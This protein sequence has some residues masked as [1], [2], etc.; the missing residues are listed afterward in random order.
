MTDNLKLDKLDPTGEDAWGN[1][2]AQF[3]NINKPE[4][5]KQSEIAATSN[6]ELASSFGAPNKER[7]KKETAKLDKLALEMRAKVNH[8]RPDAI[9][10][11]RG[12]ID[13]I[14]SDEE[15][16]W[17]GSETPSQFVD[18]AKEALGLHITDKNY[19]GTKSPAALQKDWD[20]IALKQTIKRDAGL[21]LKHFEDDRLYHYIAKA[22]YNRTGAREG[23]RMRVDPSQRESNQPAVYWTREKIIANWAREKRAR[24]EFGQVQASSKNYAQ[25]QGYNT[26]QKLDAILA[27]RLW[28]E[29]KGY[30][31]GTN[32]SAEEKIKATATAVGIVATDISTVG[33]IVVGKAASKMLGGKVVKGLAS[34]RISRAENKFRKLNKLD[35]ELSIEEAIR[36]KTD[37]SN[38]DKQI[39]LMQHSRLK[40]Q[41][42]NKVIE[43]ASNTE[44]RR[45][46][47]GTVGGDVLGTSTIEAGGQTY[48]DYQYQLAEQIKGTQ[49]NISKG[50]LF[51]ASLSGIFSALPT[52]GISSLRRSD[53]VK[54]NLH[55]ILY[56]N[57]L[58]RVKLQ[59]SKFANLNIK[60]TVDSIPA[61]TW[62]KMLERIQGNALILSSFSDKSKRGE[63]VF[64]TQQ[65]EKIDDELMLYDLFFEGNEDLGIKGVL[66]IFEDLGIGYSK[67]GRGTLTGADGKT[68][69]DNFSNWTGDLLLALPENIKK[70]MQKMFDDSLGTSGIERFQGKSLEEFIDVDA[71]RIS[72]AGKLLQQRG[73]FRNILFTEIEK[74]KT[75]KEAIE[76]ALDVPTPKVLG[77][78]M[79][80]AEFVQGGYIRGLISHLGTTGLNIKGWQW[81]SSTQSAADAVKMA[82]YMGNSGLQFLAMRGDKAGEYAAKAHGIM[83]ANSLK[84]RSLWNADTT[85]SEMNQV[86]EANPDAV[87]NLVKYFI[88]GVDNKPADVGKGFIP[89]G[90]RK[91]DNKFFDYVQVMAG[92]KAVDVF[93]KF[94]EL[95]YGLNR[96]AFE[97]YNMSHRE[98]LNSP[99]VVKI[100]QSDEYAQGMLQ[101]ANLAAKN[102]W[103][104]KYGVSKDQG[105]TLI[106][107]VAKYI[108]DM[109]RI[110]FL[111]VEIPFGQFFNNTIA[112]MVEHSPIGPLKYMMDR[113]LGYKIA[114]DDPNTFIDHLAKSA[115]GTSIIMYYANTDHMVQNIEDGLNWKQNR[116]SEGN[117]LN[118]AYKMPEI[119]FMG[120]G[121]IITY[122]RLGIEMP[123]K[124]FNEIVS[125][126]RTALQDPER[127]MGSVANSLVEAGKDV[128]ELVTTPASSFVSSIPRELVV[129]VGKTLGPGNL[130]RGLENRFDDFAESFLDIATGER[131]PVDALRAGLSDVGS[132]F[133]SGRY[134]SLDMLDVVVEQAQKDPTVRYK[135]G[136]SK[137]YWQL[138][139]YT[140][141]IFN[142]LLNTAQAPEKKSTFRVRQLKS[143]WQNS[144]L[145][146]P[147]SSFEKIMNKAG[148]SNWK[149]SNS[150]VFGEV[151]NHLDGRIFDSLERKAAVL[152]GFEPYLKAKSPA[153]VTE[154][155][156]A[157]IKSAQTEV[158][159]ELSEEFAEYNDVYSNPYTGA[160]IEERT[161]NEE[162]RLYLLMELAKS[163]GQIADI[164]REINSLDPDGDPLYTDKDTGDTIKNV[165]DLS[166]VQLNDLLI[167]YQ[168]EDTE[169][170]EDKKFIREN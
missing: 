141:N 128:S 122:G 81:A 50:R 17:L 102:T 52:L 153:K 114:P 145:N 35:P 65:G 106:Q 28:S 19:I 157:A 138:I 131:G 37:I 60:E 73:K 87:G 91:V 24:I 75:S 103:S 142:S 46:Y 63:R 12:D 160:I 158:I 84:L 136:E 95:N 18:R 88:G 66:N 9:D 148:I 120:I 44:A 27:D 47:Y 32:S 126:I 1:V 155:V 100:L 96:F 117:V 90:V 101:A 40:L 34:K 56:E 92:A 7:V 166:N 6:L 170:T 23:I 54:S 143:G 25:V 94:V 78:L 16:R 61:E 97:K 154:Y 77:K 8:S 167:S 70:E 104:K 109:R 22:E 127:S 116:D 89:E 150:N 140:D 121:R 2:W 113:S 4:L 164:N 39:L 132:R 110:P 72:D 159:K 76:A 83:R 31:W 36:N 14:N 62:E 71:K 11:N 161:H 99:D 3:Q 162:R 49:D 82:L 163:G 41:I 169:T 156:N 64:F 26:R 118:K 112:Y 119:F 59:D 124:E 146:Q 85:Y 53:A 38:M 165:Y 137:H 42:T 10:V 33:G 133:I 79:N 51:I 57:Y 151:T 152:L 144:Y 129:D 139:T 30:I 21:G 115:V 108:E 68:Y 123:D 20:D 130:F 147:P 55:P 111:G 98:L 48:A 15:T 69:K 74:G 29:Y 67:G 86:F 58:T 168:S 45:I 43:R 80:D 149:S 5:I 13:Y 107:Q 105:G 134:R 93:T 135:K 125:D